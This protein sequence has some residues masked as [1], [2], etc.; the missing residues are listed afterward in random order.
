M[1]HA[2]A[3]NS[4]SSKFI[5][6]L[7]KDLLPS[8][9]TNNQ[10]I[11]PTLRGLNRIYNPNTDNLTEV[12]SEYANSDV[13]FVRFISLLHP[14][15]PINILENAANSLSWIER[16]AVANNPTTPTEIKQKL[17]QDSNRIVRAVARE[18]LTV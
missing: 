12:L 11:S 9:K 3:N 5:K 14:L 6:D 7:L 4:N 2:V 10:L 8:S 18:N 13:V 15:T 17:T 1:R 16:Y